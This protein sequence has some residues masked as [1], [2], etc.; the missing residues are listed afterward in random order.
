MSKIL[1]EHEAVAALT[2]WYDDTTWWP[3]TEGEN[4]DI[5]GPGHQ[6]RAAFAAMVNAY[7]RHATGDDPLDVDEW[8]EADIAHGWAVLT[9][10]D[11][12]DVQFVPA[13]S[14]DE[15]AVPI[16]KLWGAR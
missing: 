6:P 4:C 1:T 13:L 11:S 8:V 9:E 5:T 7:D 2:L 3:F 12:G 10:T 16:T 15:G 14:T